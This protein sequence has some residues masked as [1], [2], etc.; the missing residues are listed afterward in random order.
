MNYGLQC[1]ILFAKN[2]YSI[3]VHGVGVYLSDNLPMASELSVEVFKY[4]SCASVFRY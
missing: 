4:F 1:I 2:V 3:H